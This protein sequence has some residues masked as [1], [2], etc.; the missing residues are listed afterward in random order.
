MKLLSTLSAWSPPSS[1][2]TLPSRQPL[3]LL[4]AGMLLLTLGWASPS[5][6]LISVPEVPQLQTDSGELGDSKREAIARS[7]KLE[8]LKKEVT[9]V[10]P[11]STRP[12]YD[13]SGQ[14]YLGERAPSYNERVL[15]TYLNYYESLEKKLESEVNAFQSDVDK[16]E[17]TL[18]EFSC[19]HE[20]DVYGVDPRRFLSDPDCRAKIE[21][22]TAHPLLYEK[23]IL[24]ARNQLTSKLTVLGKLRTQIYRYQTDTGAQ[25]A[26]IKI[27]QNESGGE[28]KI[29][30]KLAAIQRKSD[31]IQ[32]FLTQLKNQV[33]L[34]LPQLDK[35]LKDDAEQDFT[36]KKDLNPLQS[37]AVEESSNALGAFLQTELKDINLQAPPLPLTDTQK[38]SDS[39]FKALENTEE[40][41]DEWVTHTTELM[42]T[43]SLFRQNPN[44]AHLAQLKNK[45][46]HLTGLLPPGSPLIKK[47]QD[48]LEQEGV[49]P[50]AQKDLTF[51]SQ[52]LHDFVTD[53][54]YNLR[55]EIAGKDSVNKAILK[56]AGGKVERLMSYFQKGPV[57]SL[58]S[59]LHTAP[60]LHQRFYQHALPSEFYKLISSKIREHKNEIA[61]R[62]LQEGQERSIDK[63]LAEYSKHLAHLRQGKTAKG[64]DLYSSSEYKN[65]YKDINKALAE[66]PDYKRIEDL[67]GKYETSLLSEDEDEEKEEKGV[68]AHPLTHSQMTEIYHELTQK[69]GISE[70]TAKE[71]TKVLEA[72]D[73]S[74]KTLKEAEKSRPILKFES[75]LLEFNDLKNIGIAE[76]AL[77]EF[78]ARITQVQ[79]DLLK[80][81]AIDRSNSIKIDPSDSAKFENFIQ[82]YADL[83]RQLIESGNKLLKPL[84]THSD[85]KKKAAMIALEN[86]LGL[87]L[88]KIEQQRGTL[89]SSVASQ[90]KF[91]DLLTRLNAT[92]LNKTENLIS[93]D[94]RSTKA[95]ALT[96][97]AY[98]EWKSDLK[99]Q[100]AATF[101]GVAVGAVAA[102]AGMSLMPMEA[103]V[104][105]GGAIG[106]LGGWS[107]A[108]LFQDARD[109]WRNLRGTNTATN[110]VAA[111]EAVEEKR[112]EIKNQNIQLEGL[113]KELKNQ[114]SHYSALRPDT[115]FS[116]IMQVGSSFESV[117]LEG[118]RAQWEKSLEL[119]EKRRSWFS[120]L[121]NKTDDKLD[122]KKFTEK[123]K[124]EK[125][126]L[127]YS[128][129]DTEEE[130][131][132]Y[133]LRMKEVSAEKAK[134][135]E[136]WLTYLNIEKLKQDA[137]I[138]RKD[139]FKKAKIGLKS[140]E[141]NLK[142][143]LSE[144]PK[145]KNI[146]ELLHPFNRL[147]VKRK[148]SADELKEITLSLIHLR[149]DIEKRPRQSEV[150]E[151][152]FTLL[153]N[154]F[155]KSLK[156]GLTANQEHQV[157]LPYLDKE[158]DFLI[159]EA[160]IKVRKLERIGF[161]LAADYQLAQS[162]CTKAQ[163]N[164]AECRQP[165][166]VPQVGALRK[167]WRWLK[168]KAY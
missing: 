4:R 133:K 113:N 132:A 53:Y 24:H 157:D 9:S 36:N 142:W 104:G 96:A 11:G 44:E 118:K 103:R 146:A 31:E 75:A 29:A 106:G 141:K 129:G 85:T 117:E 71:Y 128:G 123:Y 88:G 134:E 136:D 78:S 153:K 21:A 27:P 1:P 154:E 23:E 69:K 25:S 100:F 26:G 70:S 39:Y 83:K 84:E 56:A 80:F 63:Q 116:K 76:K 159:S 98:K 127:H 110:A 120:Q 13:V 33:T 101:A 137:L 74:E 140:G 12:T 124:A 7:K 135:Q 156:S 50:Q 139:E 109:T 64:E 49:S 148:I 121:F 94:E 122:E 51:L 167:V 47:L 161:M 28:A 77:E 112:G 115:L 95:S 89:T 65:S 108:Y 66:N 90:K 20:E 6:A 41:V 54:R 143:I 107:T 3:F 61:N 37:L 92:A 2:V 5:F 81:M 149:D 16:Y 22:L 130:K 42:D 32:D 97:K 86:R 17:S 18:R 165:E 93:L 131:E 30:T 48:S 38:L 158:N 35:Q 151:D 59:H 10:T 87:L 155:I 160:A 40:K 79:L 52:S 45:V 68:R 105:V 152:S 166:P 162:F 119:I 168:E 34:Q 125:I 111:R 150:K 126:K 8:Y 82:I 144:L 60:T 114:P 163:T 147:N 91:A 62:P 164:I 102:G 99:Q 55:A 14:H 19:I 57:F 43:L 145:A 72:M 46:T 73:R 58:A 138:G 15:D 67:A